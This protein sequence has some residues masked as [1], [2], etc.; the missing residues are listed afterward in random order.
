MNASWDGRVRVAVTLTS[1]RVFRIC[2][3]SGAYLLYSLRKGSQSWCMDASL[4]G[5]M[6]CTI[7]GH[8]DPDLLPSF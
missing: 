4:N 6:L 5:D 3:E 2:I 8:C 1:D 7:L